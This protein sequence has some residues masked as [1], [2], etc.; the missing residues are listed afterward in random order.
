MTE[1]QI[2][3]SGLLLLGGW[4]AATVSG[5]AGFGGALLLLPL[6]AH[7]VGAKEAIPILTLA[8]LAGNLSRA[9]LGWRT[10][11]W[12]PALLFCAGAVPA[13]VLGARLFLTLPS[14]LILRTVGVFLLGVFLLGVFLLGVV[15]LRHTPL[16]KHTVPEAWLLPGGAVVG[17]LSTVVGSAGTLGA[18]LFLGLSL[19]ATTYVATEAVTATA[20]HVTKTAIYGRYG[21]MTAETWALGLALSASMILG[22]WAGKKFIERLSK[23]KF[24]ALVEVLLILAAL[25]LILTGQ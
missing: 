15:A 21:I 22:S 2:A 5:A 24:A 1:N 10:I 7:T 13:A 20:M 6:L 4:F 23:Q 19:P 18:L 17:F 3:L 9:A 8:Q 16:G 11:R 14:G 25:S 12:R